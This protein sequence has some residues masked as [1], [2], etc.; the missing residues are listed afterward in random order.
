[1]DSW[2]IE[3]FLEDAQYVMIQKGKKTMPE[4]E[5]IKLKR[6]S[7]P[8]TILSNNVGLGVSAG[9]IGKMSS[10]ELKTLTDDIKQ[11][12]PVDGYPYPV[13]DAEHIIGEPNEFYQGSVFQWAGDREFINFYHKF[14]SLTLGDSYIDVCTDEEGN[15]Y[16][17]TKAGIGGMSDYLDKMYRGLADTY[18]YVFDG[19]N[20]K[21][22]VSDVNL[23]QQLSVYSRREILG[24]F[25]PCPSENSPIGFIDCLTNGMDDK[26][27]IFRSNALS[28]KKN[29]KVIVST[30]GRKKYF[31]G[32]SK[33][34]RKYIDSIPSVVEEDGNKLKNM[35]DVNMELTTVFSYNPNA[36][37]KANREKLYV[38]LNPSDMI[39]F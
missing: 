24:T 1:M 11:Y 34:N 29:E 7:I 18:G 32:T 37:K 10:V 39:V 14:G 12:I 33:G 27:R 21:N 23:V 2:G 16:M 5:V 28:G 26:K 30:V 3:E 38:D 6:N 20:Y 9:Y 17:I 25:C 8:P 22:Y 36:R 31:I 4:Q 15:Y 19:K 35:V 13:E